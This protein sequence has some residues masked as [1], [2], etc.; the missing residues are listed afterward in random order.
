MVGTKLNGLTFA[1]SYDY[2]LQRFQQY[3]SGA[4]EIS[5]G[6]SIAGKRR[7]GNDSPADESSS[8]SFLPRSYN[9]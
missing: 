6:F 5:V 3:S 1:Y 2:G 4:H 7:A 8:T 9:N